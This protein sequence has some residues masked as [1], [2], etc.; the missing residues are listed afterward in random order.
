[1][2]SWVVVHFARVGVRSPRDRM[3]NNKWQN[4]EDVSRYYHRRHCKWTVTPV[5]SPQCCIT[6]SQPSPSSEA[7]LL[8]KANKWLN[9]QVTTPFY[10]SQLGLSRVCRTGVKKKNNNYARRLA[11]I[12][13][14]DAYDHIA[15]VTVFS[16]TAHRV[17][18]YCL[19]VCLSRS[20]L[21][22]DDMHCLTHCLMSLAA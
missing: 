11:V 15:P 8:A 6:N 21:S 9:K 5:F 19:I 18:W 3:T 4:K 13:P 17:M 7:F 22:S 2:L 10:H 14:P 16:T 12:P 1:M 20:G